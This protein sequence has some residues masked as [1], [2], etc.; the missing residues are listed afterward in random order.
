M[1]FGGEV[2]G[3]SRGRTETFDRTAP[4]P[5]AAD[6]AVKRSLEDESSQATIQVKV[7]A[8]TAQLPSKTG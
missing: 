5:G 1:R 4:P 8:R 7:S 3:K 2:Q 6:D